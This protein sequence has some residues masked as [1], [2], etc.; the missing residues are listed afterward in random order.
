MKSAQDRTAEIRPCIGILDCV[1]R[2]SP[3]RSR[4]AVN[5]AAGY[6][7][8]SRRSRSRSSRPPSAGRCSWPAVGRAG[9]RRRALPRSAATMSPCYELRRSSE[10]RQHRRPS[11]VP[12]RTTPRSPSG[13]PTSWRRSASSRAAYG[14]RPG[15]GDRDDPDVL[16]MATGS[17]P[18][19]DGRQLARPATPLPGAD[20]PHVFTSWD[21]FGFGGRSR[22]WD[23]RRGLRRHGRL[24]G[25]L[26]RR[27]ARRSRGRGHLRHRFDAFGHRI[28]ARNH[29]IAPTLRRLAAGGIELSPDRAARD[30]PRPGQVRSGDPTRDLAA[31]SVFFVGVNPPNTEL[32]DY[33]DDF[34]GEVHFVGDAAGYHSLGRR[35][36][37]VTPSDGRYDGGLSRWM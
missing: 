36:T 29:T 35:S 3:R 2:R 31:D 17:E 12:R 22:S 26:G 16:V 24:R 33:L 23:H 6:D 18:R 37:T 32:A 15:P 19:R 20:L 28:N 34:P 8:R 25:A 27:R 21:L 10:G 13:R 30:S 14:R 5:P 9:W 7:A 1:G 4:C 11:A